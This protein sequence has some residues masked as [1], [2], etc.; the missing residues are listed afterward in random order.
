MSDELRNLELH[1]TAIKSLLTYTDTLISKKIL[2]HDGYIRELVLIDF[3]INQIE[4]S[5][6]TNK[7]I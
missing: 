3:K 5:Q 4:K 7:D 2:E 6:N 1:K